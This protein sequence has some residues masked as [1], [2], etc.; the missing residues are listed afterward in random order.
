M[1][2][3]CIA[4]ALASSANEIVEIV[5]LVPDGELRNEQ[6]KSIALRWL[7]HNVRIVPESEVLGLRAISSLKEAFGSR[8]GW[9][10]QQLLRNRYLL[11]FASRPTL[12]I[13]ADTVLCQRRVWISDTNVQ[14]AT[15]TWEFHRPYYQFL[16]KLIGTPSQPEFTFVPHHMLIQ[17]DFFRYVNEKAGLLRDNDL[18]RLVVTQSFSH[19]QSAFCVIYELYAQALAAWN[20][21]LMRR[22]RWSNR[23]MLRSHQDLH[24]V[25]ELRKVSSLLGYAS[26]SLHSWS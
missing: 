6:L 23:F 20:S 25:D 11:K 19:E 2:E 8:H 7:N 4:G 9:A 26:V 16:H 18:L 3:P 22:E 21:E 12:L 13:D 10:L 14:L 15:P 17:P 5:L 24:S 1:L